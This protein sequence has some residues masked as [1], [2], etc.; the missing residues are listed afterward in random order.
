MPRT[1]KMVKNWHEEGRAFSNLLND[2]NEFFEKIKISSDCIGITSQ[3][4]LDL[5]Y[6]DTEIYNSDT[7]A[8]RKIK[9]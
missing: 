2:D 5:V 8:L 3:T 4:G 1:E 6:Y 9:N 7:N